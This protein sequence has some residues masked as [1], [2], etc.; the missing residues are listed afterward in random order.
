MRLEDNQYSHSPDGSSV[1]SEMGMKRK[2]V[3]AEELEDLHSQ[4][5]SAMGLERCGTEP[6]HFVGQKG[7]SETEAFAK[8]F[9]M[10]N[11]FI[12]RTKVEWHS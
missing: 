3:A 11:G 10:E 7:C 12:E 6:H 2:V 1:D 4:I 5:C 8:E 9:G